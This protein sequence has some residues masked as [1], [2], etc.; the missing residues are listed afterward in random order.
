MADKD[1]KEKKTCNTRT[2]VTMMRIRVAVVAEQKQEV[3]HVLSVY[4]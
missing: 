3:L 2:N 1:R 4:L